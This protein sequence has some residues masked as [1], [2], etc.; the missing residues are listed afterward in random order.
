MKATACMWIGRSSILVTQRPT[1]VGRVRILEDTWPTFLSH[2]SKH[3]IFVFMRFKGFA[4]CVLCLSLCPSSLSTPSHF[5]FSLLYTKLCPYLLNLSLKLYF[6]FKKKKELFF[7]QAC[8]SFCFWWN[9]FFL[10][11]R[12]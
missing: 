7:T 2:N 10:L 8:I 5:F 3:N 1:K 12:I 9:H 4:S 11:R 6:L